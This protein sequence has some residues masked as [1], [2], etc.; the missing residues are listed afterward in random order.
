MFEPWNSKADSG[1]NEIEL[2]C[3]LGNRN[4]PNEVEKGPQ[5]VDLLK[6]VE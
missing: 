4:L 5:G 1:A 3:E 6:F 2:L